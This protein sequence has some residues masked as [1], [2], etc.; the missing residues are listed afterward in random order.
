[1][2]EAILVALIGLFAGVV[3]VI[4]TPII[5]AIENRGSR[6]AHRRNIESAKKQLETIDYYLAVVKKVHTEQQLEQ[7]KPELENKLGEIRNTILQNPETIDEFKPYKRRSILQRILLL[8]A[9]QKSIGWLWRLLY[10]AT[11]GA[12]IAGFLDL[13]ITGEAFTGIDEE[14][15]EFSFSF[16]FGEILGAFLFFLIPVGF[17]HLATKNE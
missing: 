12:L 1:M 4:L 14:T 2:A 11:L 8:Y 15:G 16:M 3:P 9:P 13:A 5:G 6:K 10:Y 17:H 7:E